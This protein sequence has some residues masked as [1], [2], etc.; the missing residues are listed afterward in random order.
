[1]NSSSLEGSFKASTIVRRC[2]LCPF[3]QSTQL[4]TGEWRRLRKSDAPDLIR[5]EMMLDHRIEQLE[6]LDQFSFQF[7]QSIRP[8][9]PVRASVASSVYRSLDINESVEERTRLSSDQD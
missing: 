2:C 4:L 8:I 3:Q 1:M 6:F 9:F 5:F 7:D